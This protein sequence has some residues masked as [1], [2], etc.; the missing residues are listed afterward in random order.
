MSHCCPGPQGPVSHAHQGP[1]TSWLCLGSTGLAHCNSLLL[2]A[3][4]LQGPHRL[5]FSAPL[6]SLPKSYF[7]RKPS[8]TAPDLSSCFVPAFLHGCVFFKVRFEFG[9]YS[10]PS[11][12][13]GNWFQDHVSCICK[14]CIHRFSIHGCTGPTGSYL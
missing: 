6:L 8:K 12:S 11:A 9:N 13:V 4:R 14:F 3:H 5:S 10:R 7:C 1:V 2:G